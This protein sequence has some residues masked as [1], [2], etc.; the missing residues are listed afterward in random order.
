MMRP[1]TTYRNGADDKNSTSEIGITP[2][3][4][5]TK[6]DNI[7]DILKNKF[8]RIYE[9]QVTPLKSERRSVSAE[10]RTNRESNSYYAA[11]N[12]SGTNRE[13]ICIGCENQNMTEAKQQQR[14]HEKSLERHRENEF[15]AAAQV[16]YERFKREEELRL[17]EQK[18]AYKKDLEQQAWKSRSRKL[19][20]EM[21]HQSTLGWPQNAA[22]DYVRLR[23]ASKERNREKLRKV[24]RSQ[25]WGKVHE[26]GN[27]IRLRQDSSE[28]IE[29]DMY[30]DEGNIKVSSSAQKEYQKLL[31]VK[32]ALK[33]FFIC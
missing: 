11:D 21:S 14:E 32:E 7:R 5:T 16:E 13:Y 20:N 12:S 4:E 9:N 26:S 25:F 30:T 3:K 33:V 6:A 10:R 31:A 29:N 17:Y 22:V 24:I 1:L 28:N 19:S 18:S 27:K 8:Q 23:S 2:L 15:N